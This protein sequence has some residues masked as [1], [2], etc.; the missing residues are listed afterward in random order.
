MELPAGNHTV[1]WRFRAPNWTTVEAIT[2]VASLI[3]LL[4]GLV[5]VW[6]FFA[7]RPKA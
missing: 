1:E 5:A 6:I 7:K 2:L 4:G 3:I